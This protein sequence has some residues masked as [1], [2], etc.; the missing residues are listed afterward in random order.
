MGVSV[1]MLTKKK[2]NIIF[3]Q[4][5]I[6]QGPFK[7]KQ[8]IYWFILF[9]LMWSSVFHLQIVHLTCSSLVWPVCVCACALV[10][11]GLCVASVSNTARCISISMNCLTTEWFIDS[12][13]VTSLTGTFIWDQARVPAML[14][15]ILYRLVSGGMQLIPSAHSGIH[16]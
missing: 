15:A 13:A 10:R 4:S 12:L 8:V 2:Q 3:P 14:N 7:C 11:V 1:K 5:K 9:F 16:N 6:P